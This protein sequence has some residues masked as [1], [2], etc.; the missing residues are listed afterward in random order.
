ML[1]RVNG[2]DVTQYVENKS[3]QVTEQ[4]NNRANTAKI[5]FIDHR[6]TEN[7]L[8]D[9]RDT[10]KLLQTAS[11]WD[12]I[13]Y[14]EN[15][16]PE[17]ERY[18]AWLEIQIWDGVLD[19]EYATVQSYDDATHIITLASPLKNDHAKGELVLSRIFWWVITN[20]WDEQ[21]GKCGW[22]EYDCNITDYKNFLDRENVQ[23]VFE[24][25]Y[26]REILWLMLYRHASRDSEINFDDLQNAWTEWGTGLAMS[27]NS[28]IRVEGTNSQMTGTSWAGT[29]TREKTIWSSIDAT[30]YTHIRFWRRSKEGVLPTSFKI[31]AGNDASNYYEWDIPRIYDDCWNYESVR[32]DKD[33]DIVWIPDLAALN[34]IQFV[35]ASD[36]AIASDGLFFDIVS[37]STGGFTMTKV[38]RW[39][40][41]YPEIQIQDRKISAV[42]EELAKLQ[43]N[44]WNI[45]YERDISYYTKIWDW[46]AIFEVTP[47]NKNYWNL[48]IDID[49]NELKNRQKVVGG[50]APEPILRIQDEIADGEK[51]FFPLDYKAKDLKVYVSTD[52]WIN[53]IEKTVWLEWLVA[54]W[55]VDFIHTFQEKIIRNDAHP[56]LSAW[57]ILRRTYFPFKPISYR[58]ADNTNI[59]QMKLLTW[60]NGIYDGTIIIDRKI[61]TQDEAY[62]RAKAEV[63]LYKNP[64]ITISFTTNRDWLSVWDFIYCN[65][66][67]RNLDD[68]FLIQK[69]S[70]R[71]KTNRYYEYKVQAC[72]SLYGITEFFQLLLKRTEKLYLNQE[73]IVYIVEN[74]DDV[75][76][77]VDEYNLTV[78]SEEYNTATVYKRVFD[79]VYE[80]W[81]RIS[82]GSVLPLWNLWQLVI[83]WS[84]VWWVYF[85]ETTKH[86]HWHAMEV[87]TT[88][89]GVWNAIRIDT[90]GNMPIKASTEYSLEY[91]YSILTPLTSIGTATIRINL[92]EYNG[93]TLVNTNTLDADLQ[94]CDFLYKKL[95][96]TTSPTTN[97]YE[98]H[99][100]VSEC[101]TT[102][103]FADI[104]IEEQA[105]D[106]TTNP[107][108]TDFSWTI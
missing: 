9:I 95:I 7:Q 16:Y 42:A 102:I 89:G 107:A 56:L 73:S 8:I 86:N 47:T 71:Q 90:I 58:F 98:I 83:V 67:N 63:D 6:P 104:R 5:T 21:F 80:T 62:Q 65:D 13:L 19:D 24:S 49:T 43:G 75:I 53:F 35:V 10:T 1:V 34:W 93:S 99:V 25:V 33:F 23:D 29:A 2:Q 14:V 36:S 91:R 20:V 46:D 30:L 22:Y 51:D 100:L 15:T 32:F 38:I 87:R 103:Q 96:F 40:R 44:F 45:D 82:F 101:V 61:E 64:Q 52:G 94:V 55:S 68:N 59:N 70:R 85:D 3:L 11:I 76:N 12:T 105:T 78:K 72:S 54:P 92:V 97:R 77:I 108:L 31:R 37:L 106:S 27:S 81:S 74:L 69:I 57:D 84:E 79:F 28:Q 26:Y 88:I 18:Y 41:K 39:D 66:P 17:S 4:L 48:S 60:W 50:E